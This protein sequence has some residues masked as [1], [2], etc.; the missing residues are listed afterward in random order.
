VHPHAGTWLRFDALEPLLAVADLCLD[1][2]HALYEGVDPVAFYR[3]WG[4]RVGCVHLK[5]LDLARVN[6]SFW[7]AVRAGAFRPLGDGALDMRG[8]VSALLGG[9]FDG[10]CVV[11][12]DRVPGGD[13]VA[14]LVTSRERLEAVA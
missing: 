8:F 1:T 9:G 5:D 12:Q 14:D 7:D 3:R 10:W 11:E 4:N 2:G 6:G 13:P